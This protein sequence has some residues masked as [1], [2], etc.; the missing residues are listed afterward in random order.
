MKALPSYCSVPLRCKAM[1]PQPEMRSDGAVNRKKPLSLFRRLK[2]AH[3]PLAFSCWLMGVFGSIIEPVSA[4][5]S[6]AGQYTRKCGGIARS[7]S[8]TTVWATG[9]HCEVLKEGFGTVESR[10]DH[11]RQSVQRTP[12]SSRSD[13]DG[14]ALVSSIS[15]S[16]R[17]RVRTVDRARSA[18]GCQL[19]LALG[20]S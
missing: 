15:V 8:V 17:A 9:F 16:I 10:A 11:C 18:C 19:Y 6:G 5:V 7:R 2:A 20:A 3:T 1:T 4:L 14:G 12:T 13:P